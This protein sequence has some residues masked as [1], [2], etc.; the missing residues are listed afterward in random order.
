MRKICVF[1]LF[2]FIIQSQIVSIEASEIIE[3][4][5]R[6]ILAYEILDVTIN[7]T[8]LKINGWGI[9]PDQHHFKDTNSHEYELMLNSSNHSLSYSG[10]VK[11]VDL[12]R[13]M[14]YRGYP[15]C[16]TDSL[17]Q[18]DC[19]YDFKNVGFEFTVPLEDLKT[20]HRYDASLIIKSKI[21]KK[22][23]K[24]DLYY[25]KDHSVEQIHQDRNIK[26][27]SHYQTMQLESYYHTL[28]A[29]TEASPHSLELMVGEHCSN[30]YQNRA[31]FQLNSIYKNIRGIEKHDDLITY[32]KVN[33]K[34]DGCFDLRRRIIEGTIKDNFAYIPSIYVNYQ[35]EALKIHALQI[36]HQ[37]VIEAEN[38]TITQFTTFEPLDYATA[39]DVK[40]GAIT[41]KIKITFNDVN[42]L[43]PGHYKSCYEVHNSLNESH[44]KC[45]DVDV[46]KAPTYY[47]YVNNQ[48]LDSFLNESKLWNNKDLKSLIK[49]ILDRKM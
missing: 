27:E 5:Q 37:P 3:T 15:R 40:D 17:N 44:S 49:R 34:D 28:V 24:S 35:G 20:G 23:Y 42:T 46:I 9:L 21:Q 22:S 36:L 2:F 48:S 1:L 47:R 43:L 38:Q 30:G 4:N 14:E 18:K 25:P 33:V 26:L 39:H 11:K 7:N 19:N 45:I 16:S 31:Y 32:F 6:S 12:T 10:V 8:E 13:I 41:D 29:R